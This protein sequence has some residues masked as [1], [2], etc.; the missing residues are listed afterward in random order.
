MVRAQEE[1]QKKPV[2]RLAFLFYLKAVKH[3]VYILYSKKLDRFYAGETA[4]FDIRMSFHKNAHPK[5]FT[6]KAD[7]WELFLQIMCSCKLQAV[8]IETHIKKMKSS[9]YIKNLKK[10]PEMIEKLLDKHR[11]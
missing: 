3:I 9:M 7:D 4:D 5:K 1:E 10:Y 6:A 11:C 2:V 8:A